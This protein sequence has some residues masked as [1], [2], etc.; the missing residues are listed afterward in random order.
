MKDFENILNKL[1]D[2]ICEIPIEPLNESYKAQLMW[3]FDTIKEETYQL[4]S[5][6][7]YNFKKNIVDS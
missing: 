4:K 1:N 7:K 2:K 5:L 6:D 3:T